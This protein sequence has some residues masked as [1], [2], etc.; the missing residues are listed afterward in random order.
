L[1]REIT[2]DHPIGPLWVRDRKSYA[3]N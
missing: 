3:R 1:S 2:A